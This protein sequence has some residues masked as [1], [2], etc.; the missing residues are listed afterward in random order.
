MRYPFTSDLII[1]PN[2]DLLLEDSR[3]FIQFLPGVLPEQPNDLLR[4]VRHP[5]GGEYR[6]TGVMSH[7][8]ATRSSGG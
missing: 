5:S 4:A 1:N 6:G 3:R 7:L 2:E 8:K